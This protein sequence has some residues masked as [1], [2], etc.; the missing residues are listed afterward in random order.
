MPGLFIAIIAGMF[1]GGLIGSPHAG[2]PGAI[3][4]GCAGY[5][6]C[7]VAR[8]RRQLDEVQQDL[9]NLRRRHRDTA[10]AGRKEAGM[11]E[12]ANTA[13]EDDIID[14]V[15]PADS[16]HAGMA[17]PAAAFRR[18][19]LTAPPPAPEPAAEEPWPEWLANLVSGEN[20]LVKVGVVILF[21]GVAFLVKYAAQH[22]LFPLELRL[23]SA[24]LG[25]LTLLAVG[26]RLRHERPVYAQVIQGG[27]VGIVYLT[28][29]AAM[30][31][32]HLIPTGA[33]F[34]LLV[35]ICAI[36]G[37]LAVLQEAPPLAVLGSAGGFLAP[38]LASIGSGAP[39]MLFG[40]YALLNA[41]IIGIAW[42]RAWR[43]LNLLG[44]A[45]TFLVSASWGGRFYHPDHFA[46]V[47]PFLVLFFLGYTAIPLLF[48]RRQPEGERAYL[49]GTLV[50]G[51]PIVAF[52]LQAGLVQRYEYGLAWSAL[53]LGLFYLGLA[54]ILFRKAPPA[55]RLFTEAFLA[56][57]TVFATLAIPLAFDGRWT[58]AA[59]SAEGA[60]L[61]WTGLRQERRFARGFGYL[62][63]I[64]SGIAFLGET[65]L[66]TGS[67]P[68]MNGFYCGS[69]LV[70]GAALVAA[71]LL[72]RHDGLLQSWETRMEELLFAWGMVWWFGAGLHETAGHT[73]PSWENGACLAF[74]A[75]SC[76]VCGLLRPRLAW[77]LLDWPAL[78]L[79][80]A[81]AAFA[82]YLLV[83]G[84]S[85]P[86]SEGGYLAWPIAFAAWYAILKG[87]D[88]RRSRLHAVAHAA[89][90]WLM[91]I[92][93]A[94]EISWRIDSPPAGMETW[95]TTAWGVVP[96]L[97]ALLVVRYGERISWPV[98]RHY[99][100]CF[101]LGSGP[102]AFFA[103]LWLVCVNLTQAGDPWPLS[104]L[105]LLNP[106]DAATVLVLVTLACWYLKMPSALPALAAGLPHRELRAAFGGTLFL[107][108]NA[109]LLR[110]I[111]HWAGI[112]FTPHALFASQLVQTA[113]SIFWSLAALV[114]MTAAVRRSRRN[115]WLAG[116]TLLGAVVVK[117][118]LVDL[119]NSGTVERIVS[120]VV[121]GILLLVIGWFAPVPPRTGEGGAA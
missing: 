50:F 17:K 60:G 11:R 33:G 32:Y 66:P 99:P 121:V 39:A 65:G 71:R 37:A 90:L 31:L 45:C 26:W 29:F 113:V 58:A 105:L 102:L 24:A 86:A 62:L 85:H 23:A 54:A 56:F 59:W 41:G 1:I 96:A 78:G 35:A 8:L 76:G 80:P 108:L 97:L 111:H 19:P 119:A 25:G 27:G 7:A 81:M 95:A 3:W 15:E 107:W 9:E 51:T 84:E 115:A 16:V 18:A 61:V 93:L 55:M 112:E 109:M 38:E 116:A 75:L 43:G 89:P 117:L 34:A 92:L 14:L 5:L 79:L 69:L 64:G 120:F 94:W 73:I 114:V 36:A 6:L 103:W 91:A 77:P 82:A 12:P 21:F 87:A 63:L 53:A 83:T 57:G 104:Y 22:G 47:E 42:F 98:G 52:L 46:A 100:A 4:G 2:I 118:F 20:L 70:C 110:T 88:T 10:P 67:W 68:V 101:G 28:T 44:F 48:A 13:D 106:L 74:I 49:D 72:H 40:Y 30:R